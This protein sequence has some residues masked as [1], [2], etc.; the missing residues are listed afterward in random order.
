MPRKFLFAVGCLALSTAAFSGTPTTRPAGA[1]ATQ[2]ATSRPAASR[3]AKPEPRR[4]RVQHVLVAFMGTLPG[5]P[6]TRS[7]EEAEARATEALR[8]AKAGED[9]GK[10]VKEFSDDEFPGIYGLTNDGAPPAPNFS[11][12]SALVKG[13]GDVAFSLEVG[14]VRM[15]PFD[16]K[17][18]RSP[19]G[20][21]VIKR[22]E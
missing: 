20:W 16:P 13:F 14:E 5:K 15:L 4:V 9:F 8:R 1:P 7:Y 12:R 11:P 17:N 22:L 3:P 10:L 18:R 19:F 2:P 6:I 21:H